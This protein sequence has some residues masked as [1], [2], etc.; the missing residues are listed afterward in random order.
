MLAQE[1][2]GQQKQAAEEAKPKA[3]DDSTQVNTS[4]DAP[5]SHPS[6]APPEPARQQ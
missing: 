4:D 5:E 6:L 1:V 2:E 3:V